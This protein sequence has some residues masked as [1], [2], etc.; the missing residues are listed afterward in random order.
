MTDAVIDP[1]AMV[2][3][4]LSKREGS[5]PGGPL[6]RGF[7]P[8]PKGHLPLAPQLA[9]IPRE[10]PSR[11]VLNADVSMVRAPLSICGSQ[12][13][14]SRGLPGPPWDTS[15]C[16]FGQDTD[17]LWASILSSFEWG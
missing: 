9:L 16:N 12:C 11:K 2:V 1:F 3:K 6:I 13:H 4:V 7:I 15:W 8:F 5:R 10:K 17:Y 14:M